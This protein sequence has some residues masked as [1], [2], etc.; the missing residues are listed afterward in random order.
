MITVTLVFDHCNRARRGQE[1]PVEIRIISDRKS[2]YIKTGIKVTASEWRINRVVSRPD[3]DALNS[4]HAEFLAKANEAINVFI[5]KEAPLDV[6]SIRMAVSGICVKGRPNE[7]AEWIKSEIIPSKKSKSTKSLYVTI[8]HKVEAC[9]IFSTWSDVTVDNVLKFDKWL[10]CNVQRRISKTWENEDL[11]VAADVTIKAYHGKL[12]TV[13]QT[14]LKRKLLKINPYSEVMDEFRVTRRNEIKYLTEDEIEKIRTATLTNKS[15]KHSR[16]LFVFQI[17]TGLAYCDTQTFDINNYRNI[18]GKWMGTAQRK[19][20]GIKYVSQ[21][22]PPAV[23]ILE[24]YNWKAPKMSLQYY[25]ECLKK[26][27][28]KIGLAFPLRS[29]MAR[30]TFAT[31]MLSHGVKVENLAK[32][33]GHTDI[34]MTQRYAKVLAKDVYQDFEEIAKLFESNT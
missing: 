27:G 4:R 31:Y 6:S 18:K 7:V 13:F 1:G 8:Y 33:M 2:Y 14:A 32:M 12:Q 30:H 23:E 34:K 26:I 16:D 3:A 21:L 19:K 11:S 15:E 9:G 20:T 25:N 17:F 10:R 28:E 29:H 22:L 24:Q 5:N